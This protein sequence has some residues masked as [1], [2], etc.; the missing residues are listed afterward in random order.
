[1]QLADESDVLPVKNDASTAPRVQR[2]VAGRDEL[3][4]PRVS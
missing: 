1:V 3:G 2:R 4:L